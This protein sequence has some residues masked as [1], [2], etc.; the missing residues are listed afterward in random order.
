MDKLMMDKKQIDRGEEKASSNNHRIQ[1]P[2]LQIDRQIDRII[3]SAIA[4]TMKVKEVLEIC[5]QTLGGTKNNILICGPFPSKCLIEQETQ[6][7]LFEIRGK[8]SF[9][10]VVFYLRSGQ[11]RLGQVIYFLLILKLRRGFVLAR[12]LR[13]NLY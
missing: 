10:C 12:H 2:L 6:P 1:F 3:V 4:S 8:E 11:V 9:S 13:E 5:R 7:P